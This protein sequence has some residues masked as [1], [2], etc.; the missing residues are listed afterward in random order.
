M[1][2]RI[3][4]WYRTTCPICK[5]SHHCVNIPLCLELPSFSKVIVL[6]VK[7]MDQKLIFKYDNEIVVCSSSWNCRT[8]Q[9]SEFECFPSL[10]VFQV[11]KRKTSIPRC[12]VV[13]FSSDP[14][15]FFSYSRCCV[16]SVS[17]ALERMFHR[18]GVVPEGSARRSIGSWHKKCRYRRVK[19]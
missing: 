3:S 14:L 4:R 16:S 18:C 7:Q 5:G 19:L 8:G 15:V 10:L 12:C 1:K 13:F 9:A 11:G 2:I 17:L 6:N